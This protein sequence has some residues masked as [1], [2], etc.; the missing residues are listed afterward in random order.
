MPRSQ[1]KDALYQRRTFFGLQK[2]PPPKP[3]MMGYLVVQGLAVVLLVDFGFA[4]VFNGKTQIRKVAQSA[5]FW[6][7]GPEFGRV[8]ANGKER[9]VK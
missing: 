6:T 2:P 4:T 5:G 9:D 1:H 3:A 7:D 8:H